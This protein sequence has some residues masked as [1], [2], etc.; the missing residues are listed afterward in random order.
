[1][2]KQVRGYVCAVGDD[3]DTGR[4]SVLVDFSEQDS[5]K[6]SGLVCFDVTKSE[7]YDWTQLMGKT[8]TVTV[9]I[10]ETEAARPVQED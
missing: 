5:P 1:M 8:V 6:Q 2:R 3:E 4:P 7:A 10:D 9:E